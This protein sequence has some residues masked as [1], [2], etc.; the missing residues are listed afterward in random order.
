MTPSQPPNPEAEH[1]RRSSDRTRHI[2]GMYGLV[3]GGVLMAAGLAVILF[4]VFRSD[5]DLRVLGFGIG[6]VLLGG[7]AALPATFMPI[8][9]TVLRKIPGRAELPPPPALPELLDEDEDPK[10]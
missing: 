4:D 8:L 7:T 2:Y 5:G 6:L 3:A 10:P 9:T 1:R